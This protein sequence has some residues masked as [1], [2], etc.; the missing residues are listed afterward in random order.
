VGPE[1]VA[2]GDPQRR[3]L[4]TTHMLARTQQGPRI[5]RGGPCIR[6]FHALRAYAAADPDQA[7]PAEPDQAQW[8]RI[9]PEYLA[10]PDQAQDRPS[11]EVVPTHPG[12]RRRRRR[13]LTRDGLRGLEW[14]HRRRRRRRR[15]IGRLCIGRHEASCSRFGPPA[16]R[17]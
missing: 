14:P 16:S 12:R 11:N 5:D 3:G 17:E 7:R 9:R 8:T 2:P 15:P 1:R 13:A 10:D 6:A 4:R